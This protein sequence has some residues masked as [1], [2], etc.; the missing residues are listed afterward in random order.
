MEETFKEETFKEEDLV[1][2][3]FQYEIKHTDVN[4]FKIGEEVFL[5]SNPERPMKVYGFSEDN[6]Q[7]LTLFDYSIE[8]FLP[9]CLLQYKYRTLLIWR[10]KYKI[11]LN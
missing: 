1:L 7:V 2:C 10:K 3:D 4:C 6:K 9:E 8:V 5:K 11:C